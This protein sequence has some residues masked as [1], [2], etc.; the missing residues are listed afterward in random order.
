MRLLIVI[1]AAVLSAAIDPASA[2]GTS[3]AV[4]YGS[5][6]ADVARS[7]QQTT[8]GGFIV[9]GSTS[10]FG[11]GDDDA[12]IFKLGSDGSIIW[13]KTYGGPYADYAQSIQQTTDGGFI[14]AG[15]FSDSGVAWGELDTWIM[16][17]DADGNIMWHKTFGGGSSSELAKQSVDHA[18][19]SQQN[20][21][22]LSALY[23][24]TTPDAIQQTTDGGFIVAGSTGDARFGSAWILRLDDSGDSIW[25]KTFQGG[26]KSW[27]NSVQQTTDG[28]FIVTGTHKTATSA[29]WVRKL[30]TDGNVI[31]E[32]VYEDTHAEAGFIQET[33][34][35]G[36]IVAGSVRD[37]DNYSNRN[38]QILELESSGNVIWQKTYG[39]SGYDYA[40]AVHQTTDGGFIVAGST[41]SFGAGAVDAW[42]L[43][44]DGRGNIPGCGI[45]TV[46]DM[47]TE[48]TEDQ[49]FYYERSL[50]NRD[51]IS[52]QSKVTPLEI[53]AEID[54]Q[55]FFNSELRT[56][57]RLYNPNN[58]H[59]HYTT[60]QIEYNVLATYGWMQEGTACYIFDE[61]VTIDS[62]DTV[63][64]YRLYN[65]Y[66][67]EH[68]WTIDENEYNALPTYGWIQE[69]F[70]GYV[71]TTQVT[72]SEPLYRL[73][74]QSNGHHLFTRDGHE[75]DVSIGLG[76]IYEGIACYVF[77]E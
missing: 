74:N 47:V 27:A 38:A 11:A 53:D 12:W 61:V 50:T 46:T 4:T 75:K 68:H 21:T 67:G 30:D 15:G 43:K 26:L 19:F 65:P 66:T 23:A 17:I 29:M 35:G 9:A 37:P 8:D 1:L 10:S 25:Y 39:G 13:Q 49:M 64:Y 41:S 60:N 56:R 5:L 45:Y 69:G 34:G 18:G 62:A 52:G 3:W 63:P 76:W 58:G 33:S 28:G 14:A 55:C 42:I 44:I 31:W 51:V 54:Q 2:S 71:F 36:F 77:N 7:V 20:R 24:Y 40:S 73:Y 72:G 32:K 70:D 59:H 48:D 22:L 57:Y 6:D 16:K